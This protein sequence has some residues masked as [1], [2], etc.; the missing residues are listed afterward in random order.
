MA[1]YFFH[2]GFRYKRHSGVEDTTFI[3]IEQYFRRRK[4]DFKTEMF[5]EEII[6]D[7]VQL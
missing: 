3:E 6:S 5:S 1:K 4:N 2:C 7:Q